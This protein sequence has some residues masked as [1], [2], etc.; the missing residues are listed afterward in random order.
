[1]RQRA[2]AGLLSVK[3]GQH[4]PE[5]LSLELLLA[6]LFL[7]PACDVKE[8]LVTEAQFLL[9]TQEQMP[10]VRVPRARLAERRPLGYHRP[11]HH[12]SVT[13]G[14]AEVPGAVFQVDGRGHVVVREGQPSKK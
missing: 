7:Y 13:W 4:L 10:P 11:D 3:L 12:G 6:H 8:G 9:A 14:R 5:L 2:A 1:M